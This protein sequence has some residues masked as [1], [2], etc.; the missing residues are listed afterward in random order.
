MVWAAGMGSSAGF[1]DYL[2]R[3]RPRNGVVLCREVVRLARETSRSPQEAWMR[4]CWMLDAG[5]PE[6]LGN[7]PVFDRHGE[8]LG[9]PDLLDPVAGVVGEYQGAIH[10]NVARH[11]S[12][13]DREERFRSHGL[14]YFEVVAGQLSD[15]RTA[16]RMREVRRR[17]RFLDPDERCW[18]LEQ[19]AWW[20]AREARRAS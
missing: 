1:W 5:L 11:R 12:D 2:E 17:A 6:P 10:R 18:T 20:V 13:I 9:V 16:T 15:F 19:P 4:L 7:V 14:E 8:L 3:V